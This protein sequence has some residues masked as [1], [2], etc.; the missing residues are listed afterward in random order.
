MSSKTMLQTIPLILLIL[1][2][3]IILI[4]ACAPNPNTSA[5]VY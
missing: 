5:R 4:P 3:V 1:L 2:V